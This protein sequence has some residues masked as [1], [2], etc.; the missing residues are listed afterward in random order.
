VSELTNRIIVIERG[1]FITAH[2]GIVFA[3]SRP[4]KVFALVSHI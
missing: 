2:F 4:K 1:K 3:P